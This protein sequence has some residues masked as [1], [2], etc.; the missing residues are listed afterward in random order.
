LSYLKPDDATDAALVRRAQNGDWSAL[1]DLIRRYQ[2]WILHLAQRML[3]NREDAEDGAQEILLKALTRLGTFEHRSSFRTWI[4]RIAGNHLLDRCRAAKSFAAVTQ[5]LNEMPDADLP[6]PHSTRLETAL[7]IEEVKIACTTGIL[8]CLEPRQR[9][10][11]ILGEILGV[12]DDVG[13]DIL[14]TSPANFRQILSRTRR[15]LYEFLQRQCGLVNRA[16]DCRCERK[17]AGF[18]AKG[19]IRPDAPQFI[20]ERLVEIRT[21]A[22]DRYRELQE[23]ERLHAELFRQGPLLHP[24]EHATRLRELLQSAGVR[25]GMGLDL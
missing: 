16:N 22:P 25:E 10:V 13:G 6:D 11:F 24:R 20:S 21:V 15:E 7:L 19:W 3:W 23:L 12:R 17:A 9:L 8:L 5:S 18:I 1:E 14:E 4:Y 2:P